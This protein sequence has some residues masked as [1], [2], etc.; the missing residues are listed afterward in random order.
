MTSIAP[1]TPS[2]PEI[3]TVFAKKDTSARPLQACFHP[4]AVSL[5][6]RAVFAQPAMRQSRARGQSFGLRGVLA[7]HAGHAGHAGR[8]KA[9]VFAEVK[10]PRTGSKLRSSKVP[11]SGVTASVFARVP[12]SR[13]ERR[14]PRAGSA[15]GQSFG[16]RVSPAGRGQSFGLLS[17]ASFFAFTA[18]TLLPVAARWHSTS[19][20][21]RRSTSVRTARHS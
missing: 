14:V 19:N 7:G 5:H 10:V 21:P 8:V 11:R 17:P 12:R 2:L 15:R 18:S 13:A 4:I 9:S 20:S 6:R 3:R 1:R 16:L